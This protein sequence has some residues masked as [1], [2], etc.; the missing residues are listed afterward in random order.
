MRGGRFK[1]FARSHSDDRIVQD[2]VMVR[3]NVEGSERASGRAGVKRNAA[4]LGTGMRNLEACGRKRRATSL[5]PGMRTGA[6]WG[7]SSV[8]RNRKQI[9]Q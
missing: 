7:D 3:V 5:S 9:A 1:N 6:M 4:S 8:G 2:Q